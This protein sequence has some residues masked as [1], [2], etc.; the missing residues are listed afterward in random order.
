MEHFDFDEI[1]PRRGT[2]SVKWD[3]GVPDGVLP[4]WVAD[5]DFRTAPAVVEALRRRVEHGI[6]GYAIPPE[7]YAESIRGWFLRR[8]G[9]APER[10]WIHPVTGV[11][12]ALSAILRAMTRPGDKVLIQPPVYNHFYIAIANSGCTP[13]ESNLVLD[14][15]RYRIDFEDLERRAADPAVKLMLLCNPH[16]PAGRVWTPD[17]LRRIGEICL[18]HDLFIIADEIHCELVMPG[19]RYTP[20]A[21][22]DERFRQHSV[23][24]TSPSKAFNLAGL[25]V[26]NIFA[27]DPDTRGRIV[28]ALEINETGMISPFAIEALMAAY[29]EGDAW[30][31]AL[32]EYLWGNYVELRD[33]FAARLPQ[34]P[35]L[36]LEG[37]YL[38]WI[39]CRAAGLSSAELDRRLTAEAR[40]RINPRSDVR[41][42]RRGLHPGEHR[43][44]AGTAAR[45]NQ[46][47]N[48][49]VDLIIILL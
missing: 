2:C 35:V 25:Q 37:T 12:P 1:V 16:N 42:R 8:H 14:G 17:E 45:G 21:S 10:E 5:M 20:F 26:A 9:W 33:H 18:R 27:A 22:L 40:V 24:C 15:N 46:T 11:I 44:P 4:M 3:D 43:L 19:F 41:C 30:L 7:A 6:Y 29:N 23:T 38:V 32:N 39:D 36:P 49:S 47:H 13:E 31:D 34:F 48:R 28:R